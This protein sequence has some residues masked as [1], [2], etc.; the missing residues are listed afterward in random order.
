[1]SLNTNG[2]IA[3]VPWHGAICCCVVTHAYRRPAAGG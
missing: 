1:M 2:F 3:I